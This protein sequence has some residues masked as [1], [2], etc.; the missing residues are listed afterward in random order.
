MKSGK[1]LA[2]VIYTTATHASLLHDITDT[3]CQIKNGSPHNNVFRAFKCHC[4]NQ[5]DNKSTEKLQ[6]MFVC[7]WFDC[8]NSI[9]TDRA[10]DASCLDDPSNALT[11]SK[12]ML[13]FFQSSE[14]EEQ[15]KGRGE[16]GSSSHEAVTLPQFQSQ[17]PSS[18][19]CH[20]Q[21]KVV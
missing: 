11:S 6:L 4:F 1:R 14:T 7:F 8:F 12:L 3:D 13:I 21:K 10:C 17:L 5:P 16:Y 20:P 15:R 2:N 19:Y 18:V 9:P